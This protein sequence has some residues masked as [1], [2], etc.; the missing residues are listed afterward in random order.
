MLIDSTL[1]NTICVGILLSGVVIMSAQSM[2]WLRI[3]ISV[4]SVAFAVYMGVRGNRKADVKE[5]EARIRSETR[6][7]TKL[8]EL[9]STS[10]DTRDSIKA[11]GEEINS[12]N[13]R[14]ITVEERLDSTVNRLNV[15]ETRI[16]SGGV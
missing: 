15:L 6:T 7:D 9:I 2:E 14:L 3:L 8:D 11:L 13:N 5:V 4:V 12:H 16:N 10:R 1:G